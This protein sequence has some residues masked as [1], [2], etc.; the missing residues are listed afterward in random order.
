MTTAFATK[1]YTVSSSIVDLS[2]FGFSESDLLRMELG[3]IYTKA[4]ILVTYDGENDPVASPEFGIYLASGTI[5]SITGHENLDQL[6][7]LRAGATDS[8]V[9]ITLEYGE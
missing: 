6:E 9:T 1:Q 7:M 3:T 4:D 2:D 5:F 8:L